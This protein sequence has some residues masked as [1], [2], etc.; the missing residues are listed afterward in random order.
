MIEEQDICT[1][2]TRREELL[3]KIVET[4]LDN[5][6]FNQKWFPVKNRHQ[7]PTRG[8]KHYIEYK[9]R[10]DRLRKTP[11]YT[12]RRIANKMMNV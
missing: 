5:E 3:E 12:M 7:Y 4:S 11:L 8:E 2:A 10:T 9:T 1:L 6:K